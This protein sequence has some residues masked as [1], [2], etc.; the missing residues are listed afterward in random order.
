[1]AEKRSADVQRAALHVALVPI[2]MKL[3]VLTAMATRRTQVP[4]AR[5]KLGQLRAR[6]IFSAGL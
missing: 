4:A 5:S 3:P 2:D 6:G 1:M